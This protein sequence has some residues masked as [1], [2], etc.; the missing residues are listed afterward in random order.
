MRS[1]DRL[2]ALCCAR[3]AAFGGVAGCSASMGDHVGAATGG[4][5]ARDR[6]GRSAPRRKPPAPAASRRARRRPRRPTSPVSPAHAAR[7]RRCARAACA[8]AGG[9]CRAAL[10]RLAQ[11][12]P[13]LRRPACQPRPDPAPGRKAAGSRR[14]TRDRGQAQP[15]PA[16]LPGTSSAS[17]TARPASSRR[18]ATP[19]RRRSRSTRATPPRCSTWASF[20]TSTSTTARGRS[21]C[22][23][24]TSV[25]QPS[26]DAT[27]TKWVADLKNRK[28]APITVSRKEKE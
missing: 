7:L 10:S 3:R 17:P 21:S 2:A 26:G 15:A 27:V 1:V 6:G 16:G 5:P 28:P 20:T 25:L 18:R 23:A 22:T 19:T 8:P 11:A 14:R 4:A 12:H 24:A 9:R 13:E